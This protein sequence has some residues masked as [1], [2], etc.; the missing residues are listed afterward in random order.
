MEAVELIAAAD[1]SALVGR[2][3]RC[4]DAAARFVGIHKCRVSSYNRRTVVHLSLF[5]NPAG[6]VVVH[7]TG[8]SWLA[9]LAL[10]LW[11][12]HRRLYLAFVALLPLTLML[13]NGVADAIMWATQDDMLVALLALGWLVAWSV[14]AGRYANVVHRRWLQRRGYAMTATELPREAPSR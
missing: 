12:L 7:R 14:L 9:V 6:R 11:A 2:R 1:Y 5:M 13:H 8:F 4:A 10:P 3:V